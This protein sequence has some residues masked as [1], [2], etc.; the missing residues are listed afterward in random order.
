MKKSLLSLVFTCCSLLLFAQQAV[1]KENASPKLLKYYERALE[2]AR[3]GQ[4]AEALKQLN[5]A[6]R[7]APNFVDALLLKGQIYYDGAS[8]AEAETS[9][10]TAVAL[11][12]NYDP[13]AWYPLALSRLRQEKYAEAAR[14]FEQFLSFP[15]RNDQLRQRAVKYAANARFA[16]EAVNH[17]VPF[18]PKPLEEGINTPAP[19]S[20][21]SLTADG[22]TL[23]FTRIVNRQEDF[24]I[25]FRQTD[26]TWSIAQPVEGVNSP[27][28]EGAQCISADGR[29]LVFNVCNTP[30]GLGSCD[31]YRSQKIG[32]RW[33]R[34]ENLGAPVNSKWL[35]RQP[36]LSADGSTLYFSSDR[37]GGFG[38]RDIWK[39]RLNPNGTWIQ[40]E[41][42]GPN[43]NTNGNDDCPFL[44]ADGR[45]LFFMSDGHPGMGGFDL[46]TA[47]IDDRGNFEKS[48]NLGYPINTPANEGALILTL[49]GKTAYYTSDGLDQQNGPNT[50]LF[51]FE[52]PEH[53]RPAPATYVRAVVRD[54]LTKKLLSAGATLYRL[55]DNYPVQSVN[56]DEQGA[57]LFCIPTGLKYALHIESPGYIFHSEHFQPPAEA[58]ITAPYILEI[59]LNTVTAVADKPSAPVTLRNVFFETG[60]ATLLPESKAE[61]ERLFIFIEANP[62]IRIEVHG[63][64]DDVGAEADNLKLSE[65]RAGAVCSF[66]HQKGVPKERLSFKGFGESSP[67][68]PNDTP[69][70]RRQNRRTEFVILP[71]D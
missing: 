63:Y 67:V 57:F 7:E 38:G 69:E 42:L 34:P 41:N 71:G 68:A 24:F 33:S 47:R 14:D 49:D 50:D 37:P 22:K 26:N 36:A 13:K 56:T 11:S 4:P 39:S 1:I 2:Y 54:A 19:E 65:Q 51:Y 43:I 61:L 62:K 27:F 52:L 25:S 5:T 3:G 45:T 20:L 29:T 59:N 66:L 48:Q 35:E 44:H 64:T 60:S 16:A 9:L 15:T 17:P 70:G 6:L 12:P 55:H 18:N 10:A 32:N 28:N 8:F 30:D 31:I 40:P 58:E 21:P 53:L 23:V 46:Y